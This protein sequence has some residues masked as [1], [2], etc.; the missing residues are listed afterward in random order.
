MAQYVLE[1]VKWLDFGFI[2]SA[3]SKLATKFKDISESFK[4]R[5][6]IRATVNELNKLTDAE[7]RDIGINRS[8]I[9]SIAYES[10]TGK[11]HD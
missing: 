7:L 2:S 5:S 8:M 1:A 4:T 10:H 3:S 11:T 6:N 9:Y